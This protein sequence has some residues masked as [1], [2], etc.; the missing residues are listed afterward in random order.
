MQSCA[1]RAHSSERFW[2]A[3]IL[4]K[5][6]IILMPSL[7][8]S[9]PKLA[10]NKERLFRARKVHIKEKCRLS[11]AV[12]VMPGAHTTARYKVYGNPR[13]WED[14][15]REASGIFCRAHGDDCNILA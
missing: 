7:R 8:L 1:A 12:P 3:L 4:C 5:V 6:I 9:F 14:C 10:C 15:R 2:V 11:V 13:C